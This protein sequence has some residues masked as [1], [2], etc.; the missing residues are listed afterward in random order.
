[1]IIGRDR[2]Q[3]QQTNADEFFD[4]LFKPS[5]FVSLYNVLLIF[6]FIYPFISGTKT[7][8]LIY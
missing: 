4:V 3:N 8:L 5:C 7:K 1:M 6:V 2:R